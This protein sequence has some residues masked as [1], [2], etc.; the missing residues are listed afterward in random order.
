MVIAKTLLNKR[1]ERVALDAFCEGQTLYI[2]SPISLKLDSGISIAYT[3]WFSVA[4]VVG[5]VPGLPDS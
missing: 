4:G 1:D 3:V 5:P 2:D